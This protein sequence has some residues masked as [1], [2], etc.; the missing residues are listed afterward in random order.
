LNHL[1]LQGASNLIDGDVKSLAAIP[2]L[3]A[4]EI[5][6]ASNLTD[7]AVN[8][9]ATFPALQNLQLH[10]AGKITNA[11]LPDLA[12]SSLRHIMFQGS[13]ITREEAEEFRKDNAG[14]H[15]NVH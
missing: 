11:V 5:Q 1:S 10:Q 9:F 12:D 7:A 3:H 8:T 6:N 15:L 14:K 2:A 13:R 4:L